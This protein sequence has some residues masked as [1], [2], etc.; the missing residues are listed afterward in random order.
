ME[1]IGDYKI[2]W[3]PPL[4]KGSFGQVY[5]AMHKDRGDVVAAKCMQPPT[6][7]IQMTKQE[8]LTIETV[9]GHTNILDIIDHFDITAKDNIQYFWII[10][11]LCEL[12][13]LERYAQNY[14]LEIGHRVDIMQQVSSALAYLHNMKPYPVLHRDVKPENVLFTLKGILH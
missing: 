6:T 5:R 8:I 11:D 7:M 14:I 4:G 10:T 2:E 1:Y 13:N 12:G 9:K 3:F